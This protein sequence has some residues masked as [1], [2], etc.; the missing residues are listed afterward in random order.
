MAI[1]DSHHLERFIDNHFWRG[2]KAEH[3]KATFGKYLT[4]QRGFFG[5]KQPELTHEEFE[6]GIQ[7]LRENPNDIVSDKEVENFAQ[8]MRD[9]HGWQKAEE[10]PTKETD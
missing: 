8:K 6:E 9:H 10:P 1:I 5:E 4:P 3:V 2:P 7:K